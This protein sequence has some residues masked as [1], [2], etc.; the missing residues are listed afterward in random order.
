MPR[1]RQP[2]SPKPKGPKACPYTLIDRDSDIGKAMH[3][4]LKAARDIE[5]DNQRP[6]AELEGATIGLAWHE[7][8]KPNADGRMIL[9]KCVKTP[10]LWRETADYDFLVVINQAWWYEI[11]T[12]DE[13]RIAVLDHE[14]CHAAPALDPVTNKQ[15]LD[16]RGRKVWRL[17][18]HD[19]EEFHGVVHRHGL[20]KHDVE[21]QY[22]AA[23]AHAMRGF[24]PCELCREH[25]P[26]GY[27]ELPGNTVKRCD[28]YW[29]WMAR[30]T[31]VIPQQLQAAAS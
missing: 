19:I 31:G 1:S 21:R 10:A 3:A 18:D 11:K 14:L 13:Q 6:H 28:C 16:R 27:L 24:E 12:T 8:Y 30:K 7:G 20:Y 22:A 9:A 2:R 23:V 5:V 17:R 4:R 29:R 15:L 25:T 26:P